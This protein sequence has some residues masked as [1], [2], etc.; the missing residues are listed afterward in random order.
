MLDFKM[1]MD[2]LSNFG[3]YK[4]IFSLIDYIIKHTSKST[5]RTMH[6][7]YNKSIT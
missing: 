3:R 5:G 2:L 4:E 7:S 1:H 6:L